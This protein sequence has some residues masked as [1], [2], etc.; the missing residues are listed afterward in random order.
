MNSFCVCLLP[1]IV[2]SFLPVVIVKQINRWSRMFF[3]F[4]LYICSVTRSC[5]DIQTIKHV[6][7][8]YEH[9]MYKLYGNN[10]EHV[11][12]CHTIKSYT[13]Y[14]IFFYHQSISHYTYFSCNYIQFSLQA[15]NR[16]GKPPGDSLDAQ[17]WWN[18][19]ELC[20]TPIV[21]KK[22]IET[23]SYMLAGC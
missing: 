19:S 23:I 10:K 6:L 11:S 15:P 8:F 12:V 17:C 18:V 2:N 4:F 13:H 16:G 9:C 3:I 22:C 1:L 21:D 20:H 14:S 5:I 7:S